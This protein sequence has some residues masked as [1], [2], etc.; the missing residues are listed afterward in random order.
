MM[1]SV[2]LSARIQPDLLPSST[3]PS[4]SDHCEYGN[5][6]SDDLHRYFSTEF[7]FYLPGKYALFGNMAV[8]SVMRAVVM[9]V[10]TPV[11]TD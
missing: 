6:H 10:V 3:L 4:T 2:R 9:G 7:S 11:V 1:I 8:T 5:Q